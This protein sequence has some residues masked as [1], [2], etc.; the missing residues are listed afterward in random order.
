MDCLLLLAVSRLSSCSLLLSGLVGME[1][2][3]WLLLSTM[4]FTVFYLVFKA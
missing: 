2:E 1:G 4:S 3:Q